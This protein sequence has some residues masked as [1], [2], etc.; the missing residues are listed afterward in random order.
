[1]KPFY[2]IV[3][4]FL[5][6][7]CQQTPS[8]N[9]NISAISM[10][11][12]DAG[13]PDAGFERALQPREF[14]FPKDHYDHPAFATE[15]WYFTGILKDSELASYGYQLTL[16]RVGVNAG[17]SISD[18]DWRTNQ[19]YM[20]HLAISDIANK[21]HISAE[22]FARSAAGLAGADQQSSRIWLGA[23][24]IKASGDQFFPLQ[25]KADS[26]DIAIDLTLLAGTR[27]RVLQGDKG[28]SRKG[29]EPGNA[30]Y[31]YSHTRLPTQGS[32]RI[33]NRQYTV[34]GNSWFDR[35][36]SSSA[37]GKDQQGW[38]WFSLQLDDGRDLMFYRMRDKQGQAQIYSNGILLDKNGK[39]TTLSLE[40]VQIK[41]VKF[42]Q[43]SSQ[44]SYPVSWTLK[45]PQQNIDLLVEAAFEDQEMQHTVHYWEGAVSFSGSHNGVGYMELSG[46]AK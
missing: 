21:T 13:K 35:E 20:G 3:I 45:I 5:L 4:I 17:Q 36:W 28:F 6:T 25:I 46:Y 16:F 14:S 31:Y 15:W 12:S 37:L 10:L 44:I 42:W 8:E 41:P 7:G 39:L 9:Q 43:N 33:A 11:Q 24:S 34:N 27:P 22:Q 38:D 40:N 29:A 18:S 23:W 1:M 32:I 30:S 19:F 26:N 2:L